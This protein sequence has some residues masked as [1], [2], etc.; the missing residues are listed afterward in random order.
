[1]LTHPA[2]GAYLRACRG[3]EVHGDGSSVTVEP[4]LIGGEVNRVLAAHKHKHKLP[5]QVCP[6]ARWL[7]AK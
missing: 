2:P 5:V 7:A 6:L 3:Y 1:M 4:G